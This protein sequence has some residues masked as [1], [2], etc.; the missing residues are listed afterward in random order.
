MLG[1]N[2]A[3]DIKSAPFS[4]ILAPPP[5]SCWSVPYAVV[6][7]ECLH[8]ALGIQVRHLYN[9]GHWY[10]NLIPSYCTWSAVC[11]LILYVCRHSTDHKDLHW[12]HAQEA[13]GGVNAKLNIDPIVQLFPHSRFW[14]YEGL[15]NLELL[16]SF[17]RVEL[18]YR[19]WQCVT[20]ANSRKKPTNS[21]RSTDQWLTDTYWCCVV[22]A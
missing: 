6:T 19:G 5:G 11:P 14:E 1:S 15:G 12:S 22:E 21:S 9:Q 4:I 16:V 8:L 18:K 3:L 7:S 2:R 20:T 17:L 13:G 10:F